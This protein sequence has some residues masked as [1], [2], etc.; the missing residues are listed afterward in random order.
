MLRSINQSTLARKFSEKNLNC[1]ITFIYQIIYQVISQ[2]INFRVKSN[3]KFFRRWTACLTY[4]ICVCLRKVVS[5]KIVL[6][7][8]FFFLSYVSYVASFSGLFFFDC[9]FCIL[10]YSSREPLFQ[11]AKQLSNKY[12]IS[13]KSNAQLAWVSS[14]KSVM[15]SKI[16]F[17]LLAVIVQ[18]HSLLWG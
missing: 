13:R 18:T 11:I 4:L 7:S 12:L 5:S 15:F 9:P 8:C 14:L 1:L 3:K 10:V 17:P 2:H 16:W 6:C